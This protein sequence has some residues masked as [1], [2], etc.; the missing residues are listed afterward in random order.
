[1]TQKVAQSLPL[2]HPINLYKNKKTVGHFR[3]YK[4]S[5]VIFVSA[6]P[7]PALYSLIDQLNDFLPIPH[8][9]T[10][11]P[12]QSHLDMSPKSV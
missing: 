9:R 7:T 5:T 2:H 8:F 1:M 6:I 3:I 4:Y 12:F 11:V 10:T